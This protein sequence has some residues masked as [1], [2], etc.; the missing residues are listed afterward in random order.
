MLEIS[1]PYGFVILCTFPGMI[2]S[3]S[4]FFTLERSGP[5][6]A[7]NSGMASG[8]GGPKKRFVVADQPASDKAGQGE[9]LRL[10]FTSWTVYVRRDPQ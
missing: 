2:R 4:D 1:M 9:V 7:D 3:V 10:T 8:A 6:R 5:R